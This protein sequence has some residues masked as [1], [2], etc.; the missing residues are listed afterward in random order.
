MLAWGISDYFIAIA[1]RKA[2]VTKV[3]LYFLV[4]TVIIF[5]VMM[6]HFSLGIISYA[7]IS[8]I[9]VLGIIIT[10]GN[11]SFSKSLHDGNVSIVV[12][13]ASA[14]VIITVVLSLLL[15]NEV[16]TKLELVGAIMIIAGVLLASFKLR[17]LK[18]SRIKNISKGVPFAVITAISWG[19]YYYIIGSFT[20]RVGWFQAAFLYNLPAIFFMAMFGLVAHKDISFPKVPVVFLIAGLALL[21]VIGLLGYNLSVTYGYIALSAPITSAAVIV[22]VLLALVFLEERPE[23]NQLL[24]I[25]LVIAGIIAVSI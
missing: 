14:W 16:L 24:G 23:K 20:L 21:N 18:K 2:G 9:V 17:D 12:P 15:L 10:V 11:L 19:V 3:S 13:I 5:V 25:A 4:F 8:T 1:V 22:T 6:L 7:S